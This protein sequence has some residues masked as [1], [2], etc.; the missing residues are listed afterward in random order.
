MESPG[1]TVRTSYDKNPPK[2][3]QIYGLAFISVLF[4]FLGVSVLLLFYWKT[5]AEVASTR[6]IACPLAKYCK[7]GDSNDG[8]IYGVSI[9]FPNSFSD[10]TDGEVLSFPYY[11]SYTYPT[12]KTMTITVDTSNT[13]PVT[14]TRYQGNASLGVSGTFPDYTLYLSG[15]SAR[16][17]IADAVAAIFAWAI[18]SGNTVMRKRA[19]MRIDSLVPYNITGGKHYLNYSIVVSTVSE[20]ATSLSVSSDTSGSILLSGTNSLTFSPSALTKSEG[21][22]NVY[23]D[24]NFINKENVAKTFFNNDGETI[25][26]YEFCVDPGFIS[27][28][29]IG[30]SYNPDTGRW[31]NPTGDPDNPPPDIGSDWSAF[32]DTDEV[33][34]RG[35]CSFHLSPIQEGE[36]PDTVPNKTPLYQM[37]EFSQETMDDILKN[38]DRYATL[39]YEYGGKKLADIEEQSAYV[40]SIVFCGGPKKSDDN[41]NTNNATQPYDAKWPNKTG[42]A[43]G[44]TSIGF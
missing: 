12:E 1:V 24:Y 38:P 28:S 20:S 42:E 25:K 5:L 26:K 30:K 19:F 2:V 34:G 4:I 14:G 15:F 37:N 18:K 31:Y 16:E 44:Y 39:E 6:Q 35:F 36:Y 33:S 40:Q 3:P 23:G 32:A 43:D 11:D 10:Y 27:E 13:V 17:N 9:F 8:S 22:V 21:Y 7:E 41:Y 29:C